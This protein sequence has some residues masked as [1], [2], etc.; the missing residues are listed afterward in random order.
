MKK[1]NR[2]SV[3][4][5][6]LYRLPSMQAAVFR[7]L[8]KALF[9][10]SF[11]EFTARFVNFWTSARITGGTEFS[12]S[13]S[14]SLIFLQIKI[15]WSLKNSSLGG[16]SQLELS[17]FNNSF[18]RSRFRS[19]STLALRAFHTPRLR[20]A[21]WRV[22]KCTAPSLPGGL[23][24]PVNFSAIPGAALVAYMCSGRKN[25]EQIESR[26]PTQKDVRV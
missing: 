13:A 19:K 21:A 17:R 26:S 9:R 18:A 2:P 7:A 24:A 1:T 5:R 12:T 11:A 4:Q 3:G 23:R 14:F 10:L 6:L 25:R 8:S 15:L 22:R 20:K 16:Q